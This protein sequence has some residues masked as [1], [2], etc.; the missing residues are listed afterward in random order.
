MRIGTALGKYWICKRAPG[1]AFEAMECIGGMGVM[2]NTIMPRLYREAPVNAIWEGS[3]NVQCLDL[4]RILRKT[5]HALEA[6]FAELERAR[7]AHAALDRAIDALGLGLAD[8]QPDEYT[9]RS[10]MQ[11]LATTFQA[12]TLVLY[13]DRRVAEAFCAARLAQPAQGLYGNLPAG[14]DGFGL[15]ERATPV[16]G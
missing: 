8:P 13:G 1:H 3:G 7:G 12:A 6:L 15:V 2:E 5:P 11:S 10:V 9:L 16:V 4:L 14:L